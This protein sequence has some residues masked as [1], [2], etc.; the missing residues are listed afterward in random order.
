[1]HDNGMT[2]APMLLISC[3]HCAAASGFRCRLARFD[4]HVRRNRIGAGVRFVRIVHKV[5]RDRR[6]R[7]GTRTKFISSKARRVRRV[8]DRSAIIAPIIASNFAELADAKCPHSRHWSRGRFA[9]STQ[10]R[11]PGGIEEGG[12]G[13]HKLRSEDPSLLIDTFSEANRAQPDH[14]CSQPSQKPS[15]NNTRAESSIFGAN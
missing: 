6:L 4:R 10:S 7:I 13:N 3:C 14:A 2:I 11:R 12:V 8:L 1:L 5:N 9:C 15:H